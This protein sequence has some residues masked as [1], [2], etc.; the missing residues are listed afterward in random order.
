M[1]FIPVMQSWIFSIITFER[2]CTCL[3]EY[4]TDAFKPKYIVYMN[5]YCKK[6]T[7]NI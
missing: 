7:L 3:Y 1:A 6:Y 5:K 4:K 2:Q